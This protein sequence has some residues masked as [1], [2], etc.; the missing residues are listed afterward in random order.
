MTPT[1][2]LKGTLESQ[3]TQPTGLGFRAVLTEGGPQVHFYREAVD[4]E[5]L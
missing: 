5:S 1:T 2:A 3:K 4:N